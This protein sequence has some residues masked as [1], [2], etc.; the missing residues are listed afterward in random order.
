MFLVPLGQVEKIVLLGPQHP[1][2]CLPHHPRRVLVDA[3]GR[4]DAV[5]LV[6]LMSTA[7]QHL[8]ETAVERIANRVGRGLGQAKANHCGL[9]RPHLELIVRGGLGSLQ[10]RIY[11]FLFACD[12]EIVDPVLDIRSRVRR[13]EDPLIIGLVLREE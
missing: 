13:A 2:Q 8:L 1:R 7:L 11:G 10:P 3:R 9:S 4:Y 12:D 5:E 6:G